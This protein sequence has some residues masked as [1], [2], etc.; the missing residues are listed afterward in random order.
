MN[1]LFEVNTLD[2]TLE[3]FPCSNDENL[4]AWDSADQYV[5]E[6]IEQLADK[7]NNILI[8]ND[9]FGALVCG[10]AQYDITA[11]SDSYIAKQAYFYNIERNNLTSSYQYI[12]QLHQVTTPPDLVVL[13][14]P[15]S[16][17]M[18]IEQLTQL[19]NV[20]APSTTVIGLAKAKDIRTSTLALFEKYLGTTTTSLAKKKSRLIFCQP[21]ADKLNKNLTTQIKKW[22]INK[23]ALSISNLP[24]V[25]ANTSLD[26]GAQLM[27]ENIPQNIGYASVID[28]GCGNGVLGLAA[29]AMNPDAQVTFSDESFMAVESARLN[30]GNN[31]EQPQRCDFMWNDCLTD[32]EF[33]SVDWIICNPPF[34][35]LQTITDHI[36]WQMFN[37]AYRVLKRGGTLRIVGNRHLGYHIKLQRIF[38]NCTTVASNGKFVILEAVRR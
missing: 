2:L 33:D 31:I 14:L 11:Q 12:N 5:L 35:Q 29:A 10:L 37:D 17:T 9:T 21:Q 28:L 23:P 26:I 8:I 19:A 20:I 6:H 24:G 22:S 30:V 13:K 25:F 27:I 16:N 18:L 32:I 1:T 34:H 36:A 38:D 7:P 4:Q 3:R 15:K